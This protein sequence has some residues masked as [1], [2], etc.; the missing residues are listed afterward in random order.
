VNAG[1]GQRGDDGGSGA[2]PIAPK[3][4]AADTGRLVRRIALVLVGSFVFTFSLVPLYRIACEKVLGLKLQEGPAGQQQVAGLSQDTKR[5]VT[6]EFDGSVNSALPWG[7]HPSKHS[8]QVHPGQLYDATYWAQNRSDHAI[9]GN[10]APSIT[11]SEASS[12]FHKTECFCFTQQTLQAGE[13]KLMPVKFFVDP[14]LPA[15]VNT[16]TLSYT[17]FTNETATARLAARDT[18]VAARTTP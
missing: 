2:E 13:Q 14:Q 9:V 12:Y 4:H 1:D 6:V 5:T 8:M 15:G 3:P 10:A 16:V 18:P 17:F 7:F 11:P